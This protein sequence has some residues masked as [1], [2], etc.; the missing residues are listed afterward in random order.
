MQELET[1][2][3]YF[4]L[5]PLSFIL[6]LI[7]IFIHKKIKEK[8]QTYESLKT[9]VYE[10]KIKIKELLATYRLRYYC[11]LAVMIALFALFFTN[12]YL[13]IDDWNLW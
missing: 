5:L 11:N 1:A 9:E 6:L 10:V 3:I 2:S 8:V 13:L 4:Y 12:L 7:P